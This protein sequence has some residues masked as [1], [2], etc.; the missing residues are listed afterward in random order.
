MQVFNFYTNRLTPPNDKLV[1]GMN[2]N[3]P[4]DIRVTSIQRVPPDFSARYSS[5]SKVYSFSMQ[6][7][8]VADPFLLGL[9]QHVHKPLDI[10]A[11][12]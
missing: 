5:L 12:R 3:L 10:D 4:A 8:K 6:T 2:A 1:L 7:G 9:S 11:M